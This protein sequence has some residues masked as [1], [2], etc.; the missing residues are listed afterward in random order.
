MKNVKV[1]RPKAFMALTSSG[2][3][4]FNPSVFRHSATQAIVLQSRAIGEIHKSVTLLTPGHGLISAIAHGAKKMGS[5]LRSTT[6]AFC[7]SRAYLYLDPV[8]K[9]Y[10]ITDMEGIRL[11]GG[12]RQQ[13]GRFYSASLWAEVLIKS[14]AG[15]DQTEASFELLRRCLDSCDTASDSEVG[16]LTSQFLW[17]YLRFTGF[18]LELASCSDCGRSLA[19]DEPFI[20]SSETDACVC[21]RC[22]ARAGE[23]TRLPAGARRYLL[24]TERMPVDQALRVGMSQDVESALNS[25]LYQHVEK[26]LDVKLNA[27]DSIRGLK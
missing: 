6:E 3:M 23:T 17:R 7:L 18:A 2:G 16:L 20:L 14:F 24:T 1:S 27:L 12:I 9:S 8:R 10:K 21:A 25:F 13:L 5:R 19:S 11:Y 22:A 4:C 15:G 26:I